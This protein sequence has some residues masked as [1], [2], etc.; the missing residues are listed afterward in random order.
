MVLLLLMMMMILILPLIMPWLCL[1]VIQ[2]EV[3]TY[4]REVVFGRHL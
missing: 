4:P 3:Q 2:M 1:P